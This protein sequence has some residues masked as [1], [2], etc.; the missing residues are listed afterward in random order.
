MLEGV[1]SSLG[2]VVVRAIFAGWL[3]ALT[4]RLLP[5]ADSSRVSIIFILTY[6]IGIGGF[7]HAIACSTKM[8][9]LV[10]TGS[11]SWNAYA[12]RFLIPT[13]IGNIIGA[14]SLVACLGHA[15]IV[16]GRK[17]LNGAQKYRYY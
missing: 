3:I 11:E 16:G 12:I 5:G 8:S 14:A 4:V 7:N 17:H 9:Y 6:L 13:L 15:Q 1:G 10:V 2:V